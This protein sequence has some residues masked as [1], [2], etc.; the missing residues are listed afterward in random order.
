MPTMSTARFLGSLPSPDFEGARLSRLIDAGLSL[1]AI[2]GGGAV[3]LGAWMDGARADAWTLMGSSSAVVLGV[4]CI[5]LLMMRLTA[6][7][8]RLVISS[9]LAGLG[10]RLALR[11][12][13]AV[14]LSPADLPMRRLPGLV[15]AI[16]GRVRALNTTAEPALPYEAAV[17]NGRLQ[18]RQI[19]SALHQD[20]DTL[21][22]VFGTIETSGSRLADD[23]RQAGDACETAHDSLAAVTDKVVTLTAAVS[24]TAAEI[25]RTSAMAIGLSDQAMTTQKVIAQLDDRSA[26]LS[27][28]LEQVN[29]V[30]KRIGAL[31]REAAVAAAQSGE[32]GRGLAPVAAGVQELAAGVLAAVA[33]MQADIAAMSGEVTEAVRSAQDIMDSVKSQ[34]EIGLAL[35]HAVTRQT[36]EIGAILHQLDKTRS[37]F[38]RLRASVEAVARHGA[39]RQAKAEMLQ[40]TAIRLPLHADLVAGLLR[41][42]PDFAPPVDFDF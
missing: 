9:L 30:V 5:G 40:E 20:A 13:R 3:W 32:A 6:C 11:P 8:P 33:A 27:A 36:E 16:A 22:E 34:Q 26:Q 35:S 31:G 25:R 19:V 29:R 28:S 37:G 2:A 12:R 39:A 15:T 4:A 42:I 17:R 38:G 14:V 23:A 21:S 7:L 18:A 24:G 1:S 41:D 10:V